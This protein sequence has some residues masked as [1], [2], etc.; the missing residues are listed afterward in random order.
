MANHVNSAH[1]NLDSTAS[2]PGSKRNVK[3]FA[4]VSSQDENFRTRAAR[5][6]KSEGKNPHRLEHEMFNFP[7][8][9]RRRCGI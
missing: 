3:N 8:K 6:D 7:I 2:K 1:K 5:F 4:F 9:Q